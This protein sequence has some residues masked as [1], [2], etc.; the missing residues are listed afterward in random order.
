M[1]DVTTTVVQH[2]LEPLPVTRRLQVRILGVTLFAIVLI[3][4]IILVP[5]TFHYRNELRSEFYD[6]AHAAGWRNAMLIAAELRR[7]ETDVDRIAMLAALEGTAS[8]VFD[9]NGASVWSSSGWDDA[10]DGLPLDVRNATELQGERNEICFALVP[11]SDM[12][13]NPLGTLVFIKPDELIRRETIA[14]VGRILGLVLV[15][16]LCTGAIVLAFVYRE[17]VRPV[18]RV[19]RANVSAA[20]G[21]GSPELISQEDI[22]R[23]ELGEI[24]RTRNQMLSSLR[25]ARETIVAKSEELERWNRLLEQRVEERSVALERQRQRTVQAEKLAA[26]GRLAASVAHELNNPLGIIGASAENLRRELQATPRHDDFQT[27]DRSLE[28]VQSQIQRCKRI[29]DSLLNF[30][31]RAPSEPEKIDVAEFLAQTLELVRH[32]ASADGKTLELDV[33]RELPAI[34]V[35]KTLLQQ[36]LINLLENALDAS[37]PGQTVSLAARGERDTLLISVRDSGSGMSREARQ[38]AFE[39]F[40]TTKPPGRGAGM[41]LTI[42]SSHV[43]AHGGTI[44]VEQADGGGTVFHVRLPFDGPLGKPT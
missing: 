8:A 2:S 26:I 29:I 11:L 44:M 16:C 14:Y 3:E 4:L 27:V 38:R 7:T 41:G 33:P 40:F 19:V 35:M 32:R 36:T 5:T 1:S 18:E 13:G 6:R 34:V 42:A 37:S 24:M 15:I 30:S 12:D 21:E 25:A 17:I 43:R 10:A 31:R 39:P 20:R 22:P 23:T 28:I 9:A